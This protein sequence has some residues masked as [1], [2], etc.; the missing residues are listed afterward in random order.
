M[1]NQGVEKLMVARLTGDTAAGL[2]YEAFREYKQTQELTLKPKYNSDTAY[3][4]NR[5]CDT[6]TEF[7]SMDVT[8]GRYGM[9][10]AEDAYATGKTVTATGGV[11]I[12]S[13]GSGA[14]YLGLLYKAPLRRK[15]TDGTPVYRYGIVYKVQFSPADDSYKT[16]QGKPD[17]S[18]VPSLTGTGITTDWSYVNAGGQEEHPCEFHIDD[19]D[20][21][22]PEDIATSWWT[23]AYIPAIAAKPALT[24]T[25]NPAANATAVALTVK[26]TA[27]FSNVI[28]QIG[29]VALV[30]STDSSV[31]ACTVLMDSSGKIVT[32]T[33]STALSASTAYVLVL[34]GAVD[35]YGQTA[36]TQTVK[37]TTAAS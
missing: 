2:I 33:P 7:D 8:L 36:P 23:G 30:K 29:G 1:A 32:V 5:V 26:P 31:V 34:S 25:T 13:G 3:A 15:H 14:P 19:D 9:T 35:C 4:D 18:Q 6:D 28:A 17:L 27:T 37:F 24:V 16:K 22:C 20:P 12:A 21:N 10:S 11:A